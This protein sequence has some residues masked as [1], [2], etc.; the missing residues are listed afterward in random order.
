[1]SS[2]NVAGNI[3]GSGSALTNLN[4]NAILNPPALINFN[5]SSTFQ[6]S[7]F[8]SGNTTLNNAT[9]C[10]S[11][12]NVAGNIIGSGT[13]LTNL[14]YNSITN[15][16]D[17]TVYATNTILNSYSTSSMLAINNLN[18]TSTTLLNTKQNNLTFSNP[19][20]NT[21]NT[22]SLKYDSAKLNIDASGNLT[23]VNGTS[24]WTTT[25]ADI[26]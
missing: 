15:K 23:V 14:N 26:Y 19:F 4:Y 3:I 13:A 1:M 8:V 12:L 11:S 10:M 16:P 24:Q 20:L 9:T 18:S 21:T 6:S 25:G 5:N 22:I 7:L 2:L 17:L